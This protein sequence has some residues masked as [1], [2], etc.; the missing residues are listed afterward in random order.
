[1]FSPSISAEAAQLPLF[2]ADPSGPQGLRYAGDMISPEEEVEVV[3]RVQKLSFSPFKFHGLEGKRRVASFGWG[4][5]FAK[6]QAYPAPEMP[7]WLGPL[8]ARVAAWA[9]VDPE[10]LQQA[11]VI[12][13]GPGAPIGWH[14]DRPI[15]EDVIGV[16]LLSSRTL[17]LRRRSGATW[18]RAAL[19]LAPRSA[20]LMQGPV[21]DEWEHSILPAEN[22]RYSVMFRNLRPSHP[23]HQKRAASPSLVIPRI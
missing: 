19:A 4:Y 14:K 10:G 15:Y 2:D 17:R 20:Y 13:Y 16:S 23:G 12:E 5:D 21:R 8:R 22:L 6:A 11:G 18:E 7:D 3:S 9:G 1:M